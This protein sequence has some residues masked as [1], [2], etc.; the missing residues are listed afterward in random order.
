MASPVGNTI[1]DSNP[2]DFLA[3]PYEVMQY[4]NPY[5]QTCVEYALIL[6]YGVSVSNALTNIKKKKKNKMRKNTCKYTAHTYTNNSKHVN[7]R[8]KKK[9]Q[10][11]R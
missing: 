1:Y 7:N 4:R 2:A 11:K 3:S 5:G 8:E 9:N 10:N 6:L